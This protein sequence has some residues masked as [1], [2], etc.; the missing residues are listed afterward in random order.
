MT[1]VYLFFSLQKKMALQSTLQSLPCVTKDSGHPYLVSGQGG[2][3]VEE[4]VLNQAAL[5]L[6]DS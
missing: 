4:Q 1:P 3:M 5:F 2:S 6:W